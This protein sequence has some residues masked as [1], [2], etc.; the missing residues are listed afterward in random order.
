[1]R[2]ESGRVQNGEMRQSG[3]GDKTDKNGLGPSE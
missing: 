3:H 2:L 1:M